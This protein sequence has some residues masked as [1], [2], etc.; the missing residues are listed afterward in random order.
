LVMGTLNPAERFY[1]GDLDVATRTQLHAR[2]QADP[3]TNRTGWWL[4]DEAV[5]STGLKSDLVAHPR[6]FMMR[7]I[8][9]VLQNNLAEFLGHSELEL[10][11][12][13]LRLPPERE[14]REPRERSALLIALRS[15]LF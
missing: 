1:S 12:G 11:I 5:K 2:A 6:T 14:V 13:E 8:E 15:L 10:L 9:A 3:L 4:P 7:H